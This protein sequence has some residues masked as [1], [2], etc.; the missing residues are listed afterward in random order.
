M[1]NCPFLTFPL[2]WSTTVNVYFGSLLSVVHKS[3]CVLSP[4]C[5][6]VGNLKQ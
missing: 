4:G 1:A 5:T 2:G 6:L 3:I